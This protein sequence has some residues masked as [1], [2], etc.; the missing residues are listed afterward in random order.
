MKQYRASERVELQ[1]RLASPE[2]L[3]ADTWSPTVWQGDLR[4]R[5]GTA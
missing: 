2:A 5:A 3:F 4:H 1:N